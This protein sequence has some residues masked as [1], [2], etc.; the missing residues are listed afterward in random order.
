MEKETTIIQS[1]KYKQDY[2]EIYRGP[3]E[4]FKNISCREFEPYIC[5]MPHAEYPSGSGCI[6]KAITDF[7]GGVV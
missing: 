4:G 7:N 1:C 6:C 2:I 3:F 5:I